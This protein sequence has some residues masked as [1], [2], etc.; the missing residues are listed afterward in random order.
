M[1]DLFCHIF[2]YKLTTSQYLQPIQSYS[3]NESYDIEWL[4]VKREYLSNLPVFESSIWMFTYKPVFR[5]KLLLVCF[6]AVLSKTPS[7]GRPTPP[8]LPSSTKCQDGLQQFHIRHKFYC[9][10]DQLHLPAFPK[11]LTKVVETFH[12][13]IVARPTVDSITCFHYHS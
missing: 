2:L 11:I 4:Q 5:S 6:F 7:L 10:F 3:V 9:P 1:Q 13:Y 12:G 8:F